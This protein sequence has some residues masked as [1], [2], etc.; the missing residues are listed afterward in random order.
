M[1]LLMASAC[2]IGSAYGAWQLVW[3]DEFSGASVDTTKWAFETGNNGGWGNLEREYYTGRTNNAYVSNGVLHIIA[4][5]E[6]TNGFP[7]TSAR[8]KTQGLFSKKYGRIEYRARLPQ[9]VGYWP[10]LWL[11]GNNIPSVGWPACG[12]MDV[13]E[14]NGNWSNQVQGTLH[15]S[16]ASNNHLQ[17]TK[18]YTLPTT[19]D[20]VTN[21]HTYSVEWA[22]NSIK[23]VVDGVTVQTWT[24]WSSSTGP[25]PAPFNQPFFIILNLAVGGSYLGYPTDPQI[26]A[27]T[28]FP[29]EVQVDYVRV[30]DDVPAAP[31]A[32]TGL[33]ASAGNARVF[34]TWDA[35][36]SGA[37]NYN[38]KRSATSGGPYTFIGS[39]ATNNYTDASAANCASYSYVVSA[40]NSVGESTNSSEATVTLGAFA[41]AVNSGG[42]AAN[43]FVAD[44]G[45]SGGTQAAPV[46]TAVDTSGLISPAPQAVYQ[47][48]RYGNFTYTFTGLTP[49]VNY[50]VRLHLA[51]TYWTNAGQR[52]FNVFINGAQVLT[53][54]DIIAAAGAPN[55]ATV[56]EFT[57]A[58]NS[59]QIVIQYVT[60]TD[61]AKS[62]GIEILLPQPSV[63]EAGNNG[64][65]SAGMTLALTASALAG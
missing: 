34:L 48:E 26:N 65:I 19:G 59:G 13:M 44:T 22:T 11:L 54:F 16:D 1:L 2:G 7:Y 64:P 62:D 3:S 51:E 42:G 29:G 27:G 30:Y 10:A 24:S 14:N 39:T 20:S 18:L 5:Q 4:R 53:N 60:V 12:E 35:S 17:Q 36:T 9:G 47:T 32:P 38:V 63:P 58:A 33:A 31:N 8:M 40:S 45:F 21:F 52:R 49:G 37:T 25:Y 61:N 57:A 50:K 46:T 43:Q 6:S 28:S 15:Y 23:W 56:Q 55:K 41:L